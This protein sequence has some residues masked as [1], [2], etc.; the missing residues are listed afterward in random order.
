MSTT[1]YTPLD[2]REGSYYIIAFLV[3]FSA[4]MALKWYS[5]FNLHIYD[6]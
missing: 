4:L 5:C 6:H 3:L 2:V 1:I